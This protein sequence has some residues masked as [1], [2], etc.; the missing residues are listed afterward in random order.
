MSGGVALW[1]AFCQWNVEHQVSTVLSSSFFSCNHRRNQEAK[2]AMGKTRK[3]TTNVQLGS[4]D[5]S[6]LKYSMKI[7]ANATDFKDS[8]S[9]FQVSVFV[10]DEYKWSLGLGGYGLDFVILLA[11][12]L[13]QGGRPQEISFCQL[14]EDEAIKTNEVNELKWSTFWMRHRG[15]KILIR[16]KCKLLCFLSHL[17]QLS[18]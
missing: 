11:V 18:T 13:S 7:W 9:N 5:D 4:G 12:F 1:R 8:V 2:G 6:F 17:L 15:W 14:Q 10:S 16:V 3:K